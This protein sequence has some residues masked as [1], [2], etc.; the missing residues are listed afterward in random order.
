VSA[1]SPQPK[2][3][4]KELAH[5]RKLFVEYYLGD[6]RGNGTKA[7]QLAG[8]EFPAEEAY[9]LLRNAQVRARIDERLAEAAMTANEVLA[10][11]SDIGRAEWRDFLEILERDEDGKP[12]RV[13]MDL[14]AKVKSLELIGKSH[15]L[16][17]DRQQIDLDGG[18][19]LEI[20]GMADE[21]LP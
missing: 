10:E 21:D 16:F 13:K 9:R 8:Y 20:V 4:R 7:A 19:R 18:V 17:T 3:T 6:A 11:L 2:P 1:S 12:V 14:G 5:R 15:S